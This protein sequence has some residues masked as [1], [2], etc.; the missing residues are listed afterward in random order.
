MLRRPPRSTRTDTLF[1]YTTLF[2][3]QAIES[4]ETEVAFWEQYLHLC[5]ID[6]PGAVNDLMRL[7]QRGNFPGMCQRQS[8]EQLRAEWP[9]KPVVERQLVEMRVHRKPEIRRLHIMPCS[10]A[11]GFSR[12]VF[13][14]V[15][16]DDMLNHAV[17]VGN[18]EASVRHLVQV[19]GIADGEIEQIH[20]PSASGEF[21]F[22]QVSDGHMRIAGA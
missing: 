4:L 20:I 12:E 9:W 14:I 8:H 13:H 18:V 10:D 17:G 11:A 7:F 2:R 6:Q 19:T 16:G 3:S 5:A 22:V 21:R 1:P 15:P